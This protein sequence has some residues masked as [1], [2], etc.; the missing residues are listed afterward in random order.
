MTSLRWRELAAAAALA[1]LDK[2][3]AAVAQAVSGGT[4]AVARNDT[5]T[6]ALRD[7]SR[8]GALTGLRWPR[9]PYYR[10]ELDGLYSPVGWRPVWTTD[11]RPTPDARAVLDLLATA[12]ERGLRPEDYD[13]AVLRSQREMSRGSTLPCRLVFSATCP[14]CASGA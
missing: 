9:F 1:A 8:A 5:I 2:P 11:G 10:D 14:T 6:S 3:S 13:A 12:E 7:W 4:S